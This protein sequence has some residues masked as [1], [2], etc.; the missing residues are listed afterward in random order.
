MSKHGEIEYKGYIAKCKFCGQVGRI[1]GWSDGIGDISCFNPK[2]SYNPFNIGNAYPIMH[3][4]GKFR[5][6]KREAI[7]RWNSFMEG[8]NGRES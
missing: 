6:S 2:C 8:D 5:T 4:S 1:F 3:Y 7:R